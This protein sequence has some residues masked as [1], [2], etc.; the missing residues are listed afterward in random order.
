M[1]TIRTSPSYPTIVTMSGIEDY[2]RVQVPPGPEGAKPLEIQISRIPLPNDR[3]AMS[4]SFFDD[5]AYMI[6]ERKGIVALAPA[7]VVLQDDNE[8]ER[9]ELEHWK[10][11]KWREWK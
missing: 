10:L 3:F 5:N 9:I 7:I 11:R 4:V 2:I 6:E 8:P 1:T